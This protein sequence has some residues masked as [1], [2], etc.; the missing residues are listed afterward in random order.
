[1]LYG[2]YIKDGSVVVV[3]QF[4]VIVQFHLVCILFILIQKIV[5]C[6]LFALVP[7]DPLDSFFPNHI[8]LR[9]ALVELFFS[10]LDMHKSREV[11]ISHDFLTQD[12]CNHE[13]LLKFKSF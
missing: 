9:A 13:F 6:L 5:A 7:I 11:S 1:V 8:V 12:K 3:L 4:G 10:I 2:G